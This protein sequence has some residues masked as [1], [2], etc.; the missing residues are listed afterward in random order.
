MMLKLTTVGIYL[1]GTSI[2]VY[3][4]AIAFRK[5]DCVCEERN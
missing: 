2:Y 1:N 5:Q 3:K 4:D